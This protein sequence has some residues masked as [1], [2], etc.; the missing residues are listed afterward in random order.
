MKKKI[1]FKNPYLDTGCGPSWGIIFHDVICHFCQQINYSFSLLN[2]ENSNKFLG[3]FP[4]VLL[5][6]QKHVFKSC[7][8]PPYQIAVSVKRYNIEW[9]SKPGIERLFSKDL[10]KFFGSLFSMSRDTRTWNNWL[11]ALSGSITGAFC[12]SEAPFDTQVGYINGKLLK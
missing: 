5:S 12:L 1:Q 7:K 10:K 6:G 11:A 4:A 8:Q 9:N 3:L 2:R